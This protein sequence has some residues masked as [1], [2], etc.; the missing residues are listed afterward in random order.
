M[1]SYSPKKRASLAP[2]VRADGARHIRGLGL[3][4]PISLTPWT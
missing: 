4:Q 1:D 3:T 2:A